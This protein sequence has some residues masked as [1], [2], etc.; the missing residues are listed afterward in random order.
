VIEVANLN[1]TGSSLYQ[2]RML[3]ILEDKAPEDCRFDQF[4]IYSREM[5]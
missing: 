1:W 4:K 2:P 3:K 5:R